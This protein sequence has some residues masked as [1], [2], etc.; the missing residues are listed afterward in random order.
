MSRPS[1][2]AKANAE[3]KIKQQ[4]TAPFSHSTDRPLKHVDGDSGDDKDTFKPERRKRKSAEDPSDTERAALKST[5]KKTRAKK[6]KEGEPEH[7]EPSTSTSAT[8]KRR[9][10]PKKIPI[11]TTDYAREDVLGWHLDQADRSEGG[12]DGVSGDDDQDP[13]RFAR[14]RIKMMVRDSSRTKNKGEGKADDPSTVLRQRKKKRTFMEMQQA[15][16]AKVAL[17]QER[18]QRKQELL[19]KKAAQEKEREEKRRLTEVR[20]MEKTRRLYLATP[21]SVEAA[22]VMQSLVAEELERQEEEEEKR[23]EEEKRMRMAETMEEQE[24]E[25]QP[26]DDDLVCQVLVPESKKLFYRWPVREELLPAIPESTFVDAAQEPDYFEE[27]GMG[28]VEELTG[29]SKKDEDYSD[30]DQEN[31]DGEQDKL[32]LSQEHSA[33]GQTGSEEEDE[34]DESEQ[35][36]GAQSDQSVEETVQQRRYRRLRERRARRARKGHHLVDRQ[37][38]PR[39]TR[40]ER[41]EDERFANTRLEAIHKLFSGEI[42]R[43]AQTQY[44]KGIPN[45]VKDLDQ[46]QKS[47]LPEFRRQAARAPIGSTLPG[48][49]QEDDLTPIQQRAIAFSAE[50]ALRKTLDRMAYVVRQGSALRMPGRPALKPFVPLGVKH[51]SNY[52]RGWD[53]VMTSATMAGIDD[54]IL[55]KVS[56]RMK[57]LLSK[58]ENP[59]YYEAVPTAKWATV[60]DAMDKETQKHKF[61]DQPSIPIQV[62]HGGVVPTKEQWEELGLPT[63]TFKSGKFVDPL[64]P[65]FSPQVAMANAAY[66]RKW[67]LIPDAGVEQVQ[68][69]NITI[70]SGTESATTRTDSISGSSDSSES[71]SSS[72]SARGNDSE[73]DAPTRSE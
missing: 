53:T 64:D 49:D 50:D 54:R 14:K 7:G 71:G 15:R 58:S 16:E 34:H 32:N 9:G 2:A 1:R 48:F 6:Q 18:A 73:S 61:K 5:T 40:H 11:P 63:P 68:K 55:K 25:P 28:F 3:D 60:K 45:R 38:A 12:T 56:M 69:S 66:R 57:N 41:H 30:T 31:E 33:I 39:R 36:E 51:L 17:A 67:H 42:A 20:E 19:E 44:R 52:E 37:E 59:H 35:D 46:F 22:Q 62:R 65:D 4:Y 29:I 21:I 72:D 26:L 23:K 70:V 8:K 43:F 10:R 13:L 27:Q 47:T 24:H